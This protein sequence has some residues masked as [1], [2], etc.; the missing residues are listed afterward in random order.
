MKF[1][2][3]IP[4]LNEKEGMKIIC[5]RI[6]REWVDQI[7]VVD[8]GSID[9]TQQF[10]IDQGYELIHQ[11][12]KGLNAAFREAW[13][14]IKGD[15]VITFSPDNNSIPEKIPELI[16]KL[17]D[18]KYDMIIVSRYFEHAKSDDDTI[19]TG[20]GNW[21]FTKSINL[22]HKGNYTDAMVMFRGYRKKIFYDLK[23]DN[24][25]YSYKLYEKLYLT[26]IGIE[27]LLSIRAAK[28]KLKIS[29]IPGD[30]PPRIGGKAKL[31]IIRWGLAYYTQVLHEIFRK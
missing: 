8:G 24:Y 4:T 11:K 7:L 21:L 14:F 2:L 27:P 28:Y 12:E 5:P 29:E 1:T 31:Q 15:Y 10:A 3:L 17:R 18:N 25:E 13:P 30:E 20:F 9:G 22:F 26:K 23:L 16:E 6:K 19:V